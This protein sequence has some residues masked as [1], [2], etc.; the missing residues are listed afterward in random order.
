MALILHHVSISWWYWHACKNSS[1]SSGQQT[2]PLF[3]AYWLEAHLRHDPNCP[4]GAITIF[5]LCWDQDL[6]LGRL[7]ICLQWWKFTRPK[8]MT[9]I[10]CKSIRRGAI[11]S[12]F[13][14]CTVCSPFTISLLLLLTP[15]LGMLPVITCKHN[16]AGNT[17]QAI[18]CENSIYNVYHVTLHCWG[19]VWTAC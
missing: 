16:T 11:L 8:K 1:L 2:I 10:Q 17:V 19:T 3:E 4:S 7:R 18:C 15:S 13:P 5:N 6:N 9:K 14:C 12:V